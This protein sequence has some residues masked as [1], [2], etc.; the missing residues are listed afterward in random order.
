M[1]KKETVFDANPCGRNLFMLSNNYDAFFILNNWKWFTQAIKDDIF[2]GSSEDIIETIDDDFYICNGHIH[3]T[4]PKRIAEKPELLLRI[5]V[6][7]AKLYIYIGIF[8]SVRKIAWQIQNK[9]KIEN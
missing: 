8:K 5:F 3:L 6:E 9:Q 2:G 4:D 7:F 1:G